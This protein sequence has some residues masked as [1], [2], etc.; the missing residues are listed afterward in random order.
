MAG[1]WKR[2]WGT[3]IDLRSWKAARLYNL[4]FRVLGLVPKEPPKRT[5][6]VV[7]G[8][9]GMWGTPLYPWQRPGEGSKVEEASYSFSTRDGG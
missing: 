6:A 1:V 5:A 9:R 4:G 3:P 8:S 2:E 7:E